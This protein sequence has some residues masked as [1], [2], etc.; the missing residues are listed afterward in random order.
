MTQT[1]LVRR[2]T[3]RNNRRVVK[4][5]SVIFASKRSRR[6]CNTRGSLRCNRFSL[7]VR[8]KFQ[9]NDSGILVISGLI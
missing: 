5:L 4:K 9:L 2:R 6:S 1:G 3:G 7:K 8:F